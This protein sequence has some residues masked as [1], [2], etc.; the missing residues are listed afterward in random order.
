MIVCSAAALRTTVS[1][2]RNNAVSHRPRSMRLPMSIIVQPTSRTI[3][4]P[5]TPD[6]VS[7]PANVCAWADA[8]RASASAS[9]SGGSDRSA[10]ARST[11]AS[12]IQVSLDNWSRTALAASAS[13]STDC[14]RDPGRFGST[15][16]DHSVEGAT[17]IISA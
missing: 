8:S 5:A 7:I 14:T 13:P 10:T 6:S 2:A 12:T 11:P 4:S 15:V 9:E 1:V 3:D 16:S 17:A